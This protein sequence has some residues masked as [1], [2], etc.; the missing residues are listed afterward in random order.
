VA[1]FFGPP[2]MCKDHL[3]FYDILFND[4]ACDRSVC[5]LTNLLTFMYSNRKIKCWWRRRGGWWWNSVLYIPLNSCNRDCA[6]GAD[7]FGGSAKGRRQIGFG[8]A[9]GCDKNGDSGRASARRLRTRRHV[10]RS[11]LQLNPRSSVAWR[12][13]PGKDRMLLD[14]RQHPRLFF[15]VHFL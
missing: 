10:L 5:V 2:C 14:G 4:L 8:A 1:D 9:A 11:D 6:E 3:W 12:R 7:S 15:V 13:R